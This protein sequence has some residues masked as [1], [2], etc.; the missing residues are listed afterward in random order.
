MNE[1]ESKD[2]GLKQLTSEQLMSICEAFNKRISQLEMDMACKSLSELLIL[3]IL[4][5][6]LNLTEV[7]MKKYNDGI[8]Q[9]V[10]RMM[11]KFMPTKTIN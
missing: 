7:E 9:D 4:K 1:Q 11:L 6:K 2:D 8:Q 3:T 10:N 5:E